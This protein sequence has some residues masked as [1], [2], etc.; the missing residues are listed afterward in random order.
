MYLEQKK[1]FLHF[2]RELIPLI[3]SKKKKKN[4]PKVFK[5][6][7]VLIMFPKRSLVTYCFYSVSYYYDYSFFSTF[8]SQLFCPRVFS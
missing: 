8:F 7:V 3:H 2:L 5:Y 4:S 1:H 6:D